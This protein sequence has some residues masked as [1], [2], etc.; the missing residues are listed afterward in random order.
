MR[1]SRGVLR[2]IPTL[3]HRATHAARLLSL[4]G[5][6]LFSNPRQQV[7]HIA[8][9]TLEAV[10]EEGVGFVVIDVEELA[11]DAEEDVGGEE[12]D[13]FVSVDEGVVHHQG[14]EEG[15]GHFAVI[16]VVAGLRTEKSAFEQAE[17]ADS[18]GAAEALDQGLVDRQGFVGG[19][20]EGGHGSALL[21]Q[22]S[23]EVVVGVHRSF[24][25]VQDF[26]AHA[27]ALNVVGNRLGQQ[28]GDALIRFR[29][30]PLEV[31]PDRRFDF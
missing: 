26:R 12:G 23:A 18:G 29:R 1:R 14:F 11:V 15:G 2:D 22:A 28:A 4:E 21:R 10:H 20:K 17:I 9:I 7:C 16:V 31:S 24:E 8:G 6:R 27:P 3:L 30:E 25:L 5:A 19:E 13:A